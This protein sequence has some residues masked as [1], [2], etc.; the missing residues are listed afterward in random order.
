VMAISGGVPSTT[1]GGGGVCAVVAEGCHASVDTRRRVHV[2]PS[3]EA[4]GATA[5]AVLR[6][7]CRAWGLGG[8]IEEVAVQCVSELAA[9]VHAHV[10]WS[11]AMGRVAW[12]YV[13]VYAGHLVVE[14][15]DPDPFVPDFGMVGDTDG[16]D[17]E[18]PPDVDSLSESGR[19]LGIV[20][21]LVGE[22]NGSYGVEVRNGG[23]GLFFALPLGRGAV[24]MA[25]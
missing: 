21:A 13:G 14:V 18:I 17:C 10:R 16:P 4:A 19:G 25:A 11:L 20:R 12:L 9:N 2:M 8:G 15:W 1:V 7:V 5:R 23:K 3:N 6:S 22:L 24:A